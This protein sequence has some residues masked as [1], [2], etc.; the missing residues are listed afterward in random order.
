MARGERPLDAGDNELLQFAADLRQ[1]RKRA[2]S[3]TYRE[4][5]V[6][7]HYSVATLSQ[8]AAGR[9]LPSLS[10]TIAYVRACGGDTREWER[11]WHRTAA[12]IAAEAARDKSGE[13]D[14]TRSG[15]QPYRGLSAFRSED[16]EWFFGR[17]QVVDDLVTRLKYG[18]F[19]AVFGASGA[20]KSSLLRAGLVPRWRG[21]GRE[22]LL[23]TP[24]PRPL[25]ET[26]L[27]LARSAGRTPEDLS[28]EL[29]EGRQALHRAVRRT[30]AEGPEDAELL[31][32]VDQFEE[33]F[34]LCRDEAE[35][36]RFVDA[37]L[38]AALAED[39]R[40]R[41]VLGVRAD[42]YAHCTRYPSLVEALRDAQVPVG[43]MSVDELRRAVVRPAVRAGLTVEGA[44]LAT[45]MAQAHGQVGVMPLLSHALLE[46]WR[47]RRGN[48]LTLEA[49]QAT[50]G[51]EGALA[52]TAE[53]FY[54]E[55]DAGQRELARQVFLRLTAFGEGTEDTRRPARL[56]ELADLD[57]D[58]GVAA[59]VDAAARARLLT[60][61]RD[62]LEL[63]HEALIRCWPRLHGWLSED[64]E[65]LRSLRRLTEAAHAWEELGRDPG[66]VYRGVRLAGAVE[67]SRGLLTV[68][69]RD[70]VDAGVAA[71]AA[72]DMATRRRARLQRRLLALMAFLLAGTVVAGLTAYDQRREALGQRSIA[73]SRAMAAQ[74]GAVAS[75]QPEASMMLAVQA[76]RTAGI[77][78]A[79]SALLSTQAAYFDGRLKG[80]SGP[81]NAVAFRPGGRELATAGADRTVVLWE[82][83]R[84]KRT[85]VLGGHTGE[86][87]AI[88]FSPNGRLLAVGTADRR[89][90]V[91]DV[92]RRRPVH[93]FPGRARGLAFAPDG[94]VLASGGSD[95]VV[96]LRDLSRG[97][98]VAVLR[99]HGDAVNAVAFTPDGSGLVS[100]GDDRTV[101]LWDVGGRRTPVVLRGHSDLVEGLA[102]SPDGKTAA[103][104]G[105]DR[106]IRLWDLTRRRTFAVLRGHSDQV[107]AVA[108]NHDGSM[109]A[110]A[111]GEGTV[112]VWDVDDHRLITSLSGHTDYAMGVA[113]GG[114]GDVLASAGFDGTTVLWD[115]NRSALI[116]HPLSGITGVAL[117][118][119]G[120]TLATGGSD[121]MVRLWDLASRRSVATLPG[122]TGA[123]GAVAFSPDGRTLVTGGS[124]RMVRLWDL[125]SRRSVATLPGHTGAV[126]AVAF[127]PDGRTLASASSDWTI[128]LWNPARRKTFASLTRHTDFVNT[129]AFSPDGRTLAT[130]GDDRTV[131]LWDLASRRGIGTL[132][133]HSG[134]VRS[135]AFGPDGRTLASAGNDGTV[136]LWD[137]TRRRPIGTLS[138]HSGAVRSVAFGP[139][140]RTLA[141]AGNDGTVRLWDSTRRRPIAT[142]SGHSGAVAAVTYARDGATVLTGGYDGTA[143]V[144]GLDVDRRIRQ[145]CR[146]VGA[147][148]P[149]QW[150]RLG[151]GIRDSSACER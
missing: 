37:L 5:E 145:V 48:A 29:A 70:F 71:Q 86:V 40:C 65:T 117:G 59:V 28:A 68:G 147:A 58:G 90:R 9:R 14:G 113:F 112:R 105:A 31:L 96:T 128:R 6:L 126:G 32:V 123:V 12:G 49:F 20:G 144:W 115:L 99:G 111:G 80:H 47:R 23:F 122:H 118:P 72:D 89:I 76:F 103:S 67:L 81:V 142:L 139:D 41:V 42:F 78:E 87:I 8:A 133:G 102:V 100:G 93:D 56:D 17:E 83:A 114:R 129:L 21:E 136:R 53:E 55:L 69:E 30:L 26:A 13:P 104:A 95:S 97:R 106:T 25:A 138:G 60:V 119:D 134:A 77:T 74:S 45:L 130:A 121:G 35:R 18:R 52:R 151:F 34:T 124:D 92:D 79:R 131:R 94:K 2:G 50:G 22:V 15:V 132:S 108:F 51:L 88:A 85:A 135:V 116:T 148:D 7:A 1:L 140:G 91:W 143:R 3:P 19:A 63:A 64:R 39:S 54:Q 57:T 109:L 33:T 107:N 27:R 11:R 62:R 75:G 61:D 146:V 73:L 141:S 101:R 10:V 43:P 46:T 137:S 4:L 66:A 44:L 82:A 16:A 98:A 36:T 24:G 120:R 38:A 150:R 149:E 127:S 84:R 125:A 110:S